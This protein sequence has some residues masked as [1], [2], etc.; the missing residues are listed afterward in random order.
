MANT[1]KFKRASGSD[2]S[3][4][5][6]AIGE[7]G[8]RTDT[9]ELFF[10]KD[11]GTV[12]K[13]SGGGGGP[14][15]KYL[16]LRN[17]ANNGAAS[18]PGND[19]T[20]VTAGTT[21][22]ITPAAA[23]TLIVSVSG[24]IQKPNAGTST[25]GITGFIVDGSRFKTATNLP[26]A[27]DFI[28]YQESGGIGEPSDNTVTSAKIVDGAIVNADINA[29][30]AIAGT[31]INP[32]FTSD[33]SI[34]NSYPSLFLTDTGHNSD[35]S[36]QNQDGIFAVKDE[37]NSVT[38]FTIN[39]S[40]DVGTGGNIEVN[41]SPPWSVAG[42][43]Y[44]NISLS[45]NDS[46]SSGFIYMGSGA[47]TNNADFDLGRI[48]FLNNTTITA[49]IT[50]TTH[51]G[52][53][54][55]G[56]LVFYTKETGQ[57]MAER[58][59]IDSSGK[60]G[61]G[62][63]SPSAK[64][65]IAGGSVD[66]NGTDDLRLRFLSSGS[67]KGGVEVA[68]NSGDMISG[69]A[70][71]DLAIRSQTNTLFSTGGNT[72][73]LRIDSSGK[74]IIPIGTTTRLGIADRTSGT[75]AGGSL[76][77]SAGAARGSGQNTGNLLLASGRGNDSANTGVIKFGYSDGADGTGLDGEW[78]R[79]DS[80]GNVGIGT[81]SPVGQLHSE[82]SGNQVIRV[83]SSTHNNFLQMGLASG[84]TFHEYKT[85][86]RLVD[87]DNGE[88]MRI[89]STGGLRVGHTTNIFN[90]ATSEKASIKQS[91]NG[92]ALTLQ[93]TNTTGGYPILWLSSTDT[94]ASQNAVIFQRTGGSIGTIT[95]SASSV[96]YNTSS[97]YRLKENEVAIS[98][99]ITRLK[100]LKPYRF[101][102]K[103]DPDTKVDGFF[104]HE[105]TAVPEAVTGTKDEVSTD[106]NGVIPKGD[107]IYQ[108]IDHS[109]LVPLLTAALQEAIGR[110]EALEAK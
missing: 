37:T 108:T 2:P 64:L 6:L 28:V 20:L 27:P 9:A 88:R 33:I 34:N 25:S 36:I 85:Q 89:D 109:K 19:F 94:T 4:S 107:P 93:S 35:F 105:V 74:I 62:T 51:T 73:R 8:L 78:M 101:N 58:M 13:V 83:S 16:E 72:E 68:T 98:D 63:T 46:S 45:G 38:R 17:A 29:S 30:A 71:N 22:A 5:D 54:D 61:I 66:I 15:F 99:G 100:T 80:S 60:V 23:N 79:I 12:A 91:A 92:H 106:E 95:T 40:G 82:G 43:N 84:D 11:D 90:T 69:S 3:A 24:V 77:V 55:D 86:Y 41:G 52:A 7:P 21:T 18:F 49:Q 104:A 32:S 48:N 110:I 103:V 96:A 39:S 59:R 70:V 56:R 76:L 75:G 31:K 53:N 10:K 65:E 26:A 102:W 44:A 87:T 81:T 14:N 67:F 42:G 47:A 97:D 1:I 50:G 57:T